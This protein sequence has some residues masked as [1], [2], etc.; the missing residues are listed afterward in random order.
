MLDGGCLLCVVC[1]IAVVPC[2]LRVVGRVLVGDAARCALC[3][4]RWLLSAVC[5]V[6]CWRLL[7]V[8][9]RVL[10]CVVLCVVHCVMLAACCS[11]VTVCRLLYAV[12]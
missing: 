9:C 4:V 1:L 8:V 10:L 7:C 12:L 11:L 3:L 5:C 2:V 6:V